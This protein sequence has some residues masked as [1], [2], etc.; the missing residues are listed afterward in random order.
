MIGKE[1][2]LF[3]L[4]APDA[5]YRGIANLYNYLFGYNG[6]DASYMLLMIRDEDLPFT[7]A[8]FAR[9]KLEEIDIAPAYR[10]EVA[11][12][13]GRSHGVDLLR[14]TEG[15][16]EGWVDEAFSSLDG[17]RIE[18]FPAA[19]EHFVDRA[20]RNFV[21]WFGYEPLVPADW[22]LTL[23]EETMRPCKM[24]DDF[25]KEYYGNANRS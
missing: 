20:V 21:R 24:S 23:D 10:Y 8:N 16:M 25:F 18:I 17:A 15:E 6:E 5:S 7:L 9:G 12:L 14:P 19:S 11:R 13:L 3:G 4:I 2:R 1:T 22:Q